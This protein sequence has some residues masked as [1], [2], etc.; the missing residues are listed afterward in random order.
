MFDRLN[1][2]KYD[3]NL[4]GQSREVKNIFKY[5]YVMQEYRNNPLSTFDHTVHDSETPEKIAYNYYKDSKLSWIILLVNDIKDRYSEWPRTETE[6][7]NSIKKTYNPEILPYFDLKRKNAI[8]QKENNELDKD[9]LQQ[10]SAR[11]V[12]QLARVD[13]DFY[14]WNGREIQENQNNFLTSWDKLTSDDKI[15]ALD[16]SKKLPV[17]YMSVDDTHKIS[18]SSYANL[19]IQKKKQYKLYSVWDNAFDNNEKNRRI[20]LLRTD[21]INDFLK[22][23]EEASK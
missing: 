7:I 11:T 9:S 3:I 4:N 23:W 19:D 20:K 21:L 13:G 6:L 14:I 15:I 10:R 18:N 17:W 12:G 8:P 2:I 16:I 5:S 22:D 1:N